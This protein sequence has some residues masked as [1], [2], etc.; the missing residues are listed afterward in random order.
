MLKGITKIFVV[1][2]V[3]MAANVINAE[4]KIV[5]NGKDIGKSFFWEKNASAVAEN[6]VAEMTLNGKKMRI[7]SLSWANKNGEGAVNIKDFKNLVLEL[8]VTGKIDKTLKMMLVDTKRKKSAPV[9]IVAFCKDEKLPTEMTKIK[10]PL[11]EFQDGA[12]FETGIIVGL[13]SSVWTKDPID[14]KIS[15]GKIAFLN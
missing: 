15:I 2:A 12:K 8:K 9:S 14:V 6:G 10:I 13:F 11:S 7:V 1:G 5:W 3:L 4:E